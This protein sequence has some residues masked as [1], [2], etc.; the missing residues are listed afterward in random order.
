MKINFNVATLPKFECIKNKNA[1]STQN[2][3]IFNYEQCDTFVKR[4]N[5]N[6]AIS[7]AK[8]I[9]KWSL[10]DFVFYY[11]HAKNSIRENV[12]IPAIKQRVG[13]KDDVMN[14][15]LLHPNSE[16]GQHMFVFSVA[17]E[18]NAH[19]AILN[20][21]NFIQ[22]VSAELEKAKE[23]YLK[24][25][26]RTVILISDAENCLKD[27]PENKKNI[28]QM[29]KWIEHSAEIPS[30]KNSNAYATTFFLSDKEFE[31]SDTLDTYY[32]IYF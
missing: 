32:G 8:S 31:L 28:E 25:H 18:M 24:T 26:E 15:V 3:N 23:R 20:S 27:T 10:D 29:K 13:I 19:L 14:V 5:I 22:N 6:S 30:D 21:E 2:S 9:G 7:Q 1:K 16:L 12:I 17:E 11:E 4:V